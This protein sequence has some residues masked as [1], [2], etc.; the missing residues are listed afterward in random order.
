MSW[1][2]RAVVVGAAAA[3]VG[4]APKAP[5]H[6]TSSGSLALSQDGRFLYA[7]DTDN[8][9]VAVVDATT[10]TPVAQVPVGRAP[11]RV[12]VGADETL[13][14]A[15]RGDGSVSVIRQGDWRE[16]ARVPVGVE[17]TGLALSPDSRRLYV[18]SSTARDQVET[19]TLTA[20]DT[21]TLT[22]AWE[23]PV[24]EEP[25]AVTVIDDGRRALVS[26]YKQGEVVEVDLVA[27]RVK[28]TGAGLYDAANASRSASLA[29]FST[30]RARALGDLVAVPDGSRVFAPVVWARE[31]AIARR[32]SASGGYYSAGG[33]CNVGAVATPGVVTL[34]TRAAPRAQVDDLTACSA[35]AVND[36]NADYPVTSLVG[37]GTGGTAAPPGAAPG[38]IQGPTVGVVDP[39]GSW[40]YLV[41]RESKNLAVMPVWRRTGDDLDFTRTGSSVRALVPVGAGADGLALSGDGLRAYVYSQFDHRIDTLEASDRSPTATLV[42]APA[43]S[44]VVA[45][46][47]LSAADAEGRRLFFDAVDPRI[48]NAAT[49]V[50]CST[51]HLE[52]REDGHVWE[53]PDGP[54]QTPALAGRHLLA[55]APYHWSGEFKT[56]QAFSAHTIVER[57]GGSGLDDATAAKLD[58]YLDGLPAAPSPIAQHDPA[59]V[60]RGQEAFARAGCGTCHSGALL[61]DNQNADVGSLS[62]AGPNRDNGLVVTGGFNVPSL[63]G[64]GRSAPYLHDGSAP[65]LEA[66][67]FGNAGDRHGVTS[68]L[69]QGEKDDLVTYL[70]SL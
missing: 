51:C 54:R 1:L 8:G 39:T 47:T 16:A 65:T 66:R 56:L 64:L 4:C 17:P 32:P 53:F 18:T 22:A 25:R 43:K 11:V 36:P 28:A 69:T 12:L 37:R 23:L 70:K 10:M 58:G 57:M 34:D 55:T 2:K 7:A 3:V 29:S 44:L 67:V 30:F 61:T 24:G 31:D 60:A 62:L 48:S 52:G 45:Q 38:A 50:A 9:V 41:N 15:N 33:P 14:V 5:A 35:G 40:L 46:D 68:T 63:L 59:A 19:G 26:L 13:F 20:I 49:H 42:V 6:P 27:A 21:A